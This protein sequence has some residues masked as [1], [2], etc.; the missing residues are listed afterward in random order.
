[1]RSPLRPIREVVQKIFTWNPAVGQTDTFPYIDLGSIDNAE[2]KIVG[3]QRVSRASAPSR[4]RQRVQVGDILVSTV[5]PNLNGVAVVDEAENDTTAS[6]GFCVIRPNT[7]EVCHRYLFHW[8]TS[9]RFIS[10]MVRK[11]SGA[12]YPAVSDRI[13]LNS[14]FPAPPLAEQQRVAK[15]LDE[16]DDLRKKRRVSLHRLE[17]LQHGLLF[18]TLKSNNHPAVKLASHN[19]VAHKGFEYRKLK[20]IAQLAT[21]HTPDRSEI[22]YWGGDIPWLTLGDIREL[23]GSIVQN[24]KEHITQAGIANS[25]AVLLPAGTVCFSRT[26]SVG[27]VTV[28]GRPL[29]TSQDFVN[30]ICGPNIDPI[31]LMWALRA[32][33]KNLLALATGSTHR[34]IY[35]P[36]VEEFA[37]ALPPI[38]EQRAFSARILEINEIK[39]Q[40]LAHLSHLDFLFASLKHR[41]FQCEL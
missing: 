27:F 22:S 40:H 38:E 25:S 37:V 36:T 39:T 18:D 10:E 34:T 1:M 24:T 31:Y 33:R 3:I 32:S 20:D 30:W 5:R 12:S 4:A 2:K 6:T 19:A 28:A 17:Q 23:D 7:Q 15:L 26:A 35:F 14:E 9:H 13:V 29:A 8:L 16:A 41:A 11:A 21:G